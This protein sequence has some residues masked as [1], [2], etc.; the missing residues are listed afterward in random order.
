MLIPDGRACT[1][2]VNAMMAEQQRGVKADREKESPCPYHPRVHIFGHYDSR[3]GASLVVGKT[4]PDAMVHYNEAVGFEPEWDAAGTDYIGR[5][6]LIVCDEAL[7]T[8]QCELLKDYGGDYNFGRI[9][10]RFRVG[11][12]EFSKWFKT[13][14]VILW[15]GKAPVLSDDGKA[16]LKYEYRLKKWDVG[17]DAFGLILT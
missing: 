15:K 17:E 1:N 7:P 12:G 2:A 5:F 13:E 9:Q 3:G 8:E 10:T 11:D 6:D 16:T 14:T 4:T